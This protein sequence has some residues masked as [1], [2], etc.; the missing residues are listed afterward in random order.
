MIQF[1]VY[2]DINNKNDSN[3][4]W[5]CEKL[6]P[7]LAY[8]T[9]KFQCRDIK[10]LLWNKKITICHTIPYYTYNMNLYVSLFPSLIE[11]LDNGYRVSV[12][13]CFTFQS[14]EYNRWICM[15]MAMTI[16]LLQMFLICNF[17]LTVPIK[18]LSVQL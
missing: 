18:R 13:F 9:Y 8:M 6:F 2:S 1:R 16:H 7:W 4:K 10:L 11:T 12:F 3:V 14:M 5:N 15:E 17:S